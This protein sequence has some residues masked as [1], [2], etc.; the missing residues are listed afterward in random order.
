MFTLRGVHRG[1]FTIYKKQMVL[2]Y[3]VHNRRCSHL[4]NVHNK[5]FHCTNGSEE[6]AFIIEGVHISGV[7]IIRGLTV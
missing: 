1:L 2:R 6:L 5:K 4:R 7:F 3:C